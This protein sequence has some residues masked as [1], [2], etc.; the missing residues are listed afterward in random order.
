MTD[1]R[2]C[3]TI[4]PKSDFR[5]GPDGF[6]RVKYAGRPQKVCRVHGKYIYFWSKSAR[7]EVGFPVSDVIEEL[8]RA[9]SS[10]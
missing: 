10:E 2:G 7:K 6:A 4:R 1:P 5:V 9:S 3:G 8:Q